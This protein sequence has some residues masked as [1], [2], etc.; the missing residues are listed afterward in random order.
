MTVVIDSGMAEADVN[1]I[2]ISFGNSNSSIA[3]TTGVRDE[4]NLL[5][6]RQICANYVTAQEGKAEVI[7]NEEGD[8]QIPSFLSYIEGEEYHGTQAKSQLVRNSKN[9]VAYF[10]DYLGQEY[11]SRES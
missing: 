10:R 8:R 9:T 5:G 3:Y 11:A 4:L 1:A 2:G 7:A 6:G